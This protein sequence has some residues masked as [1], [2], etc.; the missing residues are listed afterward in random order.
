MK[1]SDGFII[2]Y[3]PRKIIEEKQNVISLFS[4]AWKKDS[5]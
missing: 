4:E 3:F 2:F 5:K 1:F